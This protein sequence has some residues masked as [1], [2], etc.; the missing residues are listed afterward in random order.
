[1]RA[2]CRVRSRSTSAARAVHVRVR[3]IACR[4]GTDGNKACCRRLFRQA[5]CSRAAIWGGD[6]DG[7][8]LS[9]E[10]TGDGVRGGAAL[11]GWPLLRERRGKPGF[12]GGRPHTWA[13]SRALTVRQTD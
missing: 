7:A 4:S 2:T 12:K 5:A 8:A 1:M 9:H 11:P 3:A 13:G 6:H 10:R